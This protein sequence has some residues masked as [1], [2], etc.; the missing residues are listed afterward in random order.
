MVQLLMSSKNKRQVSFKN[1]IM[2]GRQNMH[3]NKAQLEACFKAF[4]YNDV[5]LDEV[6][7][8][9]NCYAE[10]LLK[11]LGATQTDSL[12]ASSYEEAT[13]VHDMNNPIDKEFYEQY[14]VV[15]DSGTLEHVFN[16]PTAIKNCMNLTK[17]GGHFI[18][19]YPANNF[20]GHGFYQF[21]S[22]LFY[23]TLT[24]E[25]GFEICDVILFVDENNTTFYS[26]PDT[27]EQFHRINYTN[28]KPVLM[29]VLAKKVSSA[30]VLIKH[31]L[32]MDYSQMKWKGKTVK[33]QRVAKKK[34]KA[35]LPPYLKNIIKAVLN[36][37]PA[38]DSINFKKPFFTKYQL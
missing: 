17:V 23:R 16:F 3:M 7:P 19:I 35:M 30:D 36:K 15:L 18:G 38:D 27:S 37:K 25:N 1:T 11:V 24:P 4:N 8:S 31:P 21:S 20:F 22:E 12:D 29:Y 34:A 13:I 9:P 32:Q 26:V 14:D 33:K 6:Y 28:S 2:I 10:P 5:D